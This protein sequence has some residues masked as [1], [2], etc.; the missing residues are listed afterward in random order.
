MRNHQVII[1]ENDALPEGM[2]W[3]LV[4]GGGRYAVFIKEG[5]DMALAFCEAWT[6]F[7]RRMSVVA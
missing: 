5:A 6:T 3:A 7:H 2:N 1:V 4:E